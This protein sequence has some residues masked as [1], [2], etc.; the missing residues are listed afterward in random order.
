MTDEAA[1]YFS[2]PLTSVEDERALAVERLW[3][4]TAPDERRARVEALYDRYNQQATT[5]AAELAARLGE[6]VP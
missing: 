5:E 3:T 4:R 1:I 6:V 2:L